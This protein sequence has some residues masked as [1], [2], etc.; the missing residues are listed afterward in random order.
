MKII[1][2]SEASALRVRQEVLLC[3]DFVHANVVRSLAFE[4]HTLEPCEVASSTVRRRGGGG[5]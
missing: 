1:P 2:H 4:L 3:T 5:R